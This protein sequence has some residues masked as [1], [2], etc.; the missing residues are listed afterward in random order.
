MKN[1][2]RV[3]VLLLLVAI[4]CVAMVSIL[5]LPSPAIEIQ[6]TLLQNIQIVTYIEKTN[7]FSK[8]FTEPFEIGYII[9]FDGT[10]YRFTNQLNKMVIF[11]NLDEFLKSEG[12][13]IKDIAIVVHNHLYPGSPSQQD[14]WLFQKLISLGFRGS[15][16]IYLPFSNTVLLFQKK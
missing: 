11:P 12:K 13:E 8:M 4:V 15:F 10:I 3:A 2:K 16:V 5:N 14:T 9:M 6:A 7:M 1:L